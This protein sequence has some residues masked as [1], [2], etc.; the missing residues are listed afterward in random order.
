VVVLIF[1]HPLPYIVLIA[2]TGDEATIFQLL[3]LSLVPKVIGVQADV[4][5]TQNL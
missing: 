2:V 4:A 5:R 3:S 1:S